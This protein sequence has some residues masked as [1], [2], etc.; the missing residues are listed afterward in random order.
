[1]DAADFSCCQPSQY[2]VN[3][4]LRDLN[5]AFVGFRQRRQPGAR[6]PPVGKS[7]SSSPSKDILSVKD[8]VTFE[9]IS[10]ILPSKGSGVTT[11]AKEMDT[12]TMPL[13][14]EVV[15]PPIAEEAEIDGNVKTTC[16]LN[17]SAE[18]VSDESTY[19]DCVED[20][21]E[22][23]TE[24]LKGN[25][26]P[27]FHRPLTLL[28]CNTSYTSSCPSIRLLEEISMETSFVTCCSSQGSSK[29][30]LEGRENVTSEAQVDFDFANCVK[31]LKETNVGM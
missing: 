4:I 1:M 14:E 23:Q 8:N 28:S 6:P 30:S 31:D 18:E 27:S 9:N 25:C 2:L 20:W 13:N 17:T 10:E 16:I 3:N 5:K 24:D 7:Y 11:S 19:G 12:I 22:W 21:L 26:H 29:E 15:N